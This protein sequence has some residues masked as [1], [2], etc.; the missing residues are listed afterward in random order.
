MQSQNINWKSPAFWPMI[1]QVVREQIG[2]PN[3]SEIVR[4][5]QGRDN[6]FQ[7]LTHQRLSDWQDKTYK[8][9][10]V[11]SEETLRDV[12]QGF[13]PGGKQTR[14]NVFV[15]FL[16]TRHTTMTNTRNRRVTLIC[17]LRSKSP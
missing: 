13:L 16:Y 7:Y 15:S 17:S 4:T 1:N 8:D 3:L 2:K 14:Y 10:I 12:Q 11:W 5:L 6:R 9:K